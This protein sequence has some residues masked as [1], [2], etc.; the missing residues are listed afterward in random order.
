[1]SAPHTLGK[2]FVDKEWSCWKV[3][4][5]RMLDEIVDNKYN[6]QSGIH[7]LVNVDKYWYYWFK[8]SDKH[9]I[10]VPPG[11]NLSQVRWSNP[12]CGENLLFPWFSHGFPMVF[13]VD[14]HGLKTPRSDSGVSWT[15]CE[16]SGHRWRRS[17]M[18]CTVEGISWKKNG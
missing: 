10:H 15:F 3:C 8:K 14:S 5:E 16:S 18:A 6:Y 4:R 11:Y 13:P 2:K 7:M 1:M 9:L 12:A 17:T